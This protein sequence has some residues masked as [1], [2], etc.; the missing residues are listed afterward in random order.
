M[1][2]LWDFMSLTAGA[3]RE[4]ESIR[5]SFQKSRYATK[6]RFLLMGSRLV[7]YD[8]KTSFINDWRANSAS[9]APISVI[10]AY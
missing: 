4:S 2:I 5:L 1:R 9:F 8:Q 10:V 3:E 7:V 6:C